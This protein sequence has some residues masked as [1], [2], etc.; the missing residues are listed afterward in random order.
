[1]TTDPQLPRTLAIEP[2]GPL[3]T[4]LTVPGSKSMTNRA[5]LV[6]ALAEGQTELEG[7]LE[8]DDTIAMRGALEQLGVPVRVRDDRWVIEGRA[9]A[10][11]VPDMT[12]DLGNAGT[13]MRFLTAAC[14]LADGV[15]VLDGNARMRERPIADL[16]EALAHLG[17]QVELLQPTECPPLRTLGGGLAGGRAEIDASQSSQYVSAVLLA[18]PYA[19]QDVR[20]G[21]RDGVIVSRPYIDVTLQVMAAFGAEASWEDDPKGLWVRAGRPYRA[22]RFAGEPD[23]SSAVY[24]LCAAAISGGRARVVGLPA[25]SKQSDIAILP[26]LEAMGCQVLRGETFVE[27]TGPDAGLRSAGTVD[28]NDLP[29]AALAYAVLAL[30]ARGPTRIENIGNLRIKETD[31][32]AALE[33]ELSRLGARVDSG[34][35]WLEIR[36]GPLRGAEIETYDD[37]RMA[38][39][40]SLAGLRIPGVAIVDPGCVSKTWPAYFDSFAGW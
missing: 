7:A 30:F 28:L 32:I 8:S 1:M 26:L 13:A 29:D 35:D 36:P 21:F 17:G 16:V 15:C 3:D 4:T 11:Q 40:F 39:A 25:D 19:R 20:L 12:L 14:T 18:A 10:L 34:A 31:R 2:R 6:A 5:L 27:V 33:T 37:H 22:R 9:G 23:A 24:P 38:M